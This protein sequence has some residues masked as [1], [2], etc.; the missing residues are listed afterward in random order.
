MRRAQGGNEMVPYRVRGDAI[1]KTN[2]PLPMTSPPP[3]EAAP[4]ARTETDF[5]LIEKRL[6]SV[7]HDVVHRGGGVPQAPHYGRQHA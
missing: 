7:K 3:A 1:R 2:F 6:Q 5:V 4:T